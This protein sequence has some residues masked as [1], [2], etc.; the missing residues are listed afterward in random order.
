MTMNHCKHLSLRQAFTTSVAGRMFIGGMGCC[1]QNRYR[2]CAHFL[3]LATWE[4][5]HLCRSLLCVR[6]RKKEPWHR[7]TM[8]QLMAVIALLGVVATI[9]Y[10]LLTKSL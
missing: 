1:G 10:D 5:F 3:Y 2:P 9:T 6:N 7:L 8:L 4:P